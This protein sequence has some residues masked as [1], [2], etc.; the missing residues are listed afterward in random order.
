MTP[1]ETPTPIRDA[2]TVLLLRPGDGPHPFEIFM[3]RRTKRAKFMASAMVFPGGRVDAAD[4]DDGLA[5]RCDLSREAAA[6]RMGMDDGAQALAL[7]VAGV[8]ETFEEAG[9][10]LARRA[11]GPL[12][13]GDAA[14][15]ARL[16]KHRD[17]LNAHETTMAAVAE[18]EDLRL[19]LDR[20]AFYARWITPPIESRRFD[21][22][23]LVARAPRGQRGQHDTV[24]TTASA[25]LAPQAALD[26]YA[27][28]DIQLAPPTLRVLLELARSASI[29]AALKTD[30]VPRPIQPQPQFVAGDLHLLLPGDPDFD[31][32]GAARN[33][34]MLR[35][36][37]WI[38]EGRG[39]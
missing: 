39:A 20:L 34:I 6:Q 31:P 19:E 1:T 26:A 38:S 21:A 23:F 12:D 7:L 33:R 17:A 30:G 4:A 25:W 29:E 35:D 13:L 14:L 28:D 10:L 27:A 32:P 5:A 3:V 16:A 9:L 37:R 36:G 11:D 15:I 24:E 8:R 2:T 18:A 22:R